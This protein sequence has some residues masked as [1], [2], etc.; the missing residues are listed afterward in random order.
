M[1]YNAVGLCADTGNLFVLR[2]RVTDKAALD[3]DAHSDK[4]P[5]V[6]RSTPQ[7]RVDNAEHML[8]EAKRMLDEA[9]AQL[10]A[11]K[12]AN[13]SQEEVATAHD[14][15]RDARAAWTAAIKCHKS[16]VDLTSTSVASGARVV[17]FSLQ[18]DMRV[19]LERPLSE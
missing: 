15:F 7:E 10:K 5:R 6:V 18:P 3:D 2:N 1:V 4:K 11:L 8:N 13:A 9:E 14:D 16:V 12:D 17:S 19:R